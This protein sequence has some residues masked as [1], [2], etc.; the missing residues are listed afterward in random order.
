VAVRVGSDLTPPAEKEMNTFSRVKVMNRD[1]FHSF[2]K[3]IVCSA[4]QRMKVVT[5]IVI[6]LAGSA[7][8]T[9]DEPSDPWKVELD[10]YLWGASIGG[11]TASGSDLDVSFGDLLKNLKMG[12]MGNVM[13]RKEKWAMFA[14]LIYLDVSKTKKSGDFL[15]QPIDTSVKLE[16]TGWISTFGGAYSLTNDAQNSLDLMVGAR[17]RYLDW[18]FDDKA[19]LEDLNFHGPSAGV[20]FVF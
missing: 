11:Q 4:V 7:S 16:L 14:D 3:S 2:G 12:F 19:S 20:R 5:V 9:A 6:L 17:Y 1:H 15:G 13:V 10:V 8:A 18:N